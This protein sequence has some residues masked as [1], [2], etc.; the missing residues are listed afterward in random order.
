MEN[1]GLIKI[2]TELLMTSERSTNKTLIASVVIIKTYV[3]PA[4][5]RIESAEQTN[6][7]NSWNKQYSRL[8]PF[9]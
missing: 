3:N 4:K 2:N 8:E 9:Y 5:T 7:R 1:N 6:D